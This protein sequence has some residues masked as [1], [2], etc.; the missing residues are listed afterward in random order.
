MGKRLKMNA[1]LPI[2][3]TTEGDI[4]EVK[5]P[6]CGKEEYEVHD[7]AGGRGE[8]I[9]EFCV[10]CNCEKIFIT[11]YVVDWVCKES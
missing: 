7:R 10:C 6:Y 11:L 5:C 2:Q 1:R 3:D 9:Q 4:M 8:D